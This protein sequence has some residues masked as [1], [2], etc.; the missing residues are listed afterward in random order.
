MATP[1]GRFGAQWR[2]V[3]E[4]LVSDLGEVFAPWIQVPETFANPDRI[5][6]F[7]P[8]RTF[9][10]FLSQVLSADGSCREAVRKFQ[11]WLALD[12]GPDASPRTPGYCKARARLGQDDIEGVSDQVTQSIQTAA[13]DQGL[14]Q[15]R[16][17][18]IADGSSLS[19]P[20][21]PTNQ[22]AYP[23]PAG[24]KPGCGF[25][26][27]RIV[28]LFSLATGALLGLARG[29]LRM[30]ERT[31]FRNLWDLFQPGDVA[32]TDCGFCSY[33]DVFLLVQRGVDVVMRNHQC[34]KVGLS[35]VKRLGQADR[36]IQWHKTKTR[37]QWIDKDEWRSMPDWLTVRE[38]TFCVPIPGFRTEEIT[39][40][41]SLL[42]PK[43][44]PKQA[45]VELYRRRWLA[46]L[47]LRDI[48]TTMGMDVLRCKSPDM[49]HKELAMHV[50][51]YNLMRA[52]MLEA[53]TAHGMSVY[54]ISFK[55]ALATVRQWAPIMGAAQLDE[56]AR[57]R[58]MERLLRCLA[59]DPL[60]DRP[61]RTEPR[62]RKRR[63]KNYQ[64]LT[65]PRDVFKETP[66]R[67]RHKALS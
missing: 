11:A 65:Q 30:A 21:T 9:W 6:L 7:S 8:S 52:L 22:Q 59:F 26:V 15:G 45:F 36:V 47:F 58:M 56:L 19:M 50:I 23:Q 32:L 16:Q 37:P 39:L 14:W 40:V 33:A 5:R 42:D 31:L 66:H 63:P 46:E 53:A 55:G 4:C 48:K 20:D 38:I 57:E 67:S 41:T 13:K 60:P 18:K 17:V 64:L 1:P 35:V 61:N 62:A 3:R 54:R 49:I 24:Q 29:S 12:N 25:P 2:R 34:R 51:A 43:A 27:M 28:A 44:F 10:L